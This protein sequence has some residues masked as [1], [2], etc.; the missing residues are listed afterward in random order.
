VFNI[1]KLPSLIEVNN[2][3]LSGTSRNLIDGLKICN[4]N[5]WYVCGNLALNE[6]I[7][8]HKLINSSPSDIDYQILLKA[9]LLLMHDSI[10]QPLTITTGFPYSTYN[11]YREEASSYIKNT[12]RIEYD[13]STYTLNGGKKTIMLDVHN[14][15][16][17][18]EIVGCTLALRKG[19]AQEKGNFFVLSCGFGTFE[20]IMSTDAGV[21]EQSMISTIGMS[22]AVNLTM[23]ELLNKYYLEFRNAHLIDEA[24][25]RGYIILNKKRIDLKELRRNSLRTYY[26]EVISPNLRS[27]ISDSNLMKSN[28][29]F[30]CGGGMYYEDLVNCFKE[31]YGEIAQL[32]IVSDPELLASKGYAL[33]SLR[34]SGGQKKSSIGIDIGN[35]TTVVT[36]PI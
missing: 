2:S 14:V 20:S 17:M 3:V 1:K 18:S 10:E 36:Q 15:E 8:P 13:E 16:V 25:Q 6:A 7:L 30:L 29:I 32:T 33:N 11:L 26:Q 31:E 5:L 34:I 19:E 12:H 27:V 28:R 9:S 35:S 21:V 23:K 22:Y 24:F 4:E